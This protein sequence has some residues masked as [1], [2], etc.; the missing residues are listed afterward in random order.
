M[1]RLSLSLQPRPQVDIEAK[2]LRSIIP[3]IGNQRGHL[4]NITEDSLRQEIDAAESG[5]TEDAVLD[6]TD[7][8]DQTVKDESKDVLAARELIV[9]QVAYALP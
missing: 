5:C 1:D 4:R 8:P 3:R 6:D 7:V 9:R 2:S